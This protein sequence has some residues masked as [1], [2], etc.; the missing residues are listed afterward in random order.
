M[1]FIKYVIGVFMVLG[2]AFIVYTMVMGDFTNS[3]LNSISGLRFIIGILGFI[4]SLGGYYII[5]REV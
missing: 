4:L 2:G 3:S 5:K 1:G